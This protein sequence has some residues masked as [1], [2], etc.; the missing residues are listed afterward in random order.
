MK[1]DGPVDP[2]VIKRAYYN[3]PVWKRVVVI[4]A[5]PV[6]NIVVAFV[7][8]FAVCLEPPGARSGLQVESVQA[9]TPAAG[10]LK[11]G[12]RLLAVDGARATMPDLS[13][14]DDATGAST[15]PTTSS[16]TSRT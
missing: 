15:W 1:R 7:L 11:P 8:L 5:G 4:A 13:K 3:Q 9:G 6:V 10:V 14:I 12:D 2:E 16:R